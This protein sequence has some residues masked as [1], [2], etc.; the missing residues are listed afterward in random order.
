MSSISAKLAFGI[1]NY[2]SSLNNRSLAAQYTPFLNVLSSW[3]LFRG[4]GKILGLY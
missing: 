4:V 3:G 2:E 1:R